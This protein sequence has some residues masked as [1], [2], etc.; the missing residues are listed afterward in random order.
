MVIVH[1][2]YLILELLSESTNEDKMAILK[3][4]NIKLSSKNNQVI[5]TDKG[6]GVLG[7]LLSSNR[8]LG[9][10]VFEPLDSENRDQNDSQENF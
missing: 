1:E 10:R 8:V 9:A 5:I 3:L 6:T 2:G 4:T 7:Y